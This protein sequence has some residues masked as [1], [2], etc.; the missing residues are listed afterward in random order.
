MEATRVMMD[1]TQKVFAEL[2]RVATSQARDASQL[3]IIA[4]TVKALDREVLRG[5]SDRPSMRSQM[6]LLTH[7]IDDLSGR[8]RTLEAE[9][10]E[11]LAEKAKEAREAAKEAKAE[12]TQK[13]QI[14]DAAEAAKHIKEKEVEVAI[15]QDRTKLLLGILSL[16]GVLAAAIFGYL[17]NSGTPPPPKTPITAAP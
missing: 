3:E 14:M 17:S 4:E 6:E 5:H 12:V 9:S 10:K 2:Q 8:V 11:S 13:I 7:G 16:V 15:K 1:M